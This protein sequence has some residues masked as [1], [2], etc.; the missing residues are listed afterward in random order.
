MLK[1]LRNARKDAEGC[2]KKSIEFFYSHFFIYGKT[3]FGHK[4]VWCAQN[5]KIFGNYAKIRLVKKHL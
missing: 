3:N 2:R 4:L 5:L 1:K